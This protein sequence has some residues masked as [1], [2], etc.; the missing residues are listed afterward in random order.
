[1]RDGDPRFLEGIFKCIDKRCKMLGLDAPAKQ[2]IS[3]PNQG[4]IEVEGGGV[5]QGLDMEHLDGLLRKHYNGELI[6]DAR[7]AD[8]QRK[9]PG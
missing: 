7:F 9:G 5:A 2:E 4:P 6:P 8:P 3:G 1:M